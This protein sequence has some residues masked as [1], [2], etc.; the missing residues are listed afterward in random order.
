[1]KKIL[2]VL[3]ILL[4]ASTAQ[5]ADVNVAVQIGQPGF[6]GRI[7]LGNTAPP[8]VVLAEPIWVQR[9]TVRPQSVYMRI[10][11]GHQKHWDKHCRK[12]NACGVPV[13]FVQED[14]Y[15]QRY[16]QHDDGHKGEK[17]K[18]HGKGHGKDK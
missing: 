13:Y 15:Q 17:N 18:G 1:M 6:Y 16:S 3:G 8:P 11:P 10:P 9:G 2:P 7:D 12:Y 4:L 5:A 14:W